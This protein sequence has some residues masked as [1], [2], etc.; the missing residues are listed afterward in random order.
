MSNSLLYE[1]MKCDIMML[2]LVL[3]MILSGSE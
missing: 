3:M 2:G 1:M